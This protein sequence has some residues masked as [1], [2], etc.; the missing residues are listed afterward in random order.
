M[1]NNHLSTT[2]S[3]TWEID[4]DIDQDVQD[5]FGLTQKQAD[6]I[7]ADSELYQDVYNQ[8]CDLYGLPHTVDMA[9]YFDRPHSMASSQIT[10]ALSDEFGFLVNDFIW[11]EESDDDHQACNSDST[12]GII[13]HQHQPTNPKEDNMTNS[14]ISNLSTP[15]N[16]E[17]PMT[18]QEMIINLFQSFTQDGGMPKITE[19]KKHLDQLIKTDIKPLCARS[20]KSADGTDW[21][22]VLKAQF[23]GRGA[24]WVKLDNSHL[25]TT[26]DKFDTEGLNTTGYRDH[27]A[28]AGF[29]W[30]RFNGPRINNG[31][32][33]AAFE[34]RLDGS[35]IDHPRQLHYIPVTDLDTVITPLGGT[36]NSMKLEVD[37]VAPTQ[38]ATQEDTPEMSDEQEREARTELAQ[39]IYGDAI[40]SN[41]ELEDILY[42]EMDDVD[43]DEFPEA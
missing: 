36:P 11:L 23:G 35:T 22:S 25:E 4:I 5:D 42:A 17:V 41:D 27:T 6:D 31:V 30:I 34:V 13:T 33:S 3:I 14:N 7:V 28:Q 15:N 29:S 37:F 40:F 12:N 24:K 43:F 18:Q 32:Q 16:T 9:T 21:R 20:G 10:D 1:Q 2:I 19:F 38:E 39:E 8:A 26:L